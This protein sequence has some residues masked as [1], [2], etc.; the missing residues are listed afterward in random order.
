MC[1]SYSTSESLTILRLPFAAA[2]P[3]SVPPSCVNIRGNISRRYQLIWPARIKKKAHAHTPTNKQRR[4]GWLRGITRNFS[5]A[6]P[7]Q[8]THAQSAHRHPFAASPKRAQ[9][10]PK[11]SPKQAQSKPK[12]SA[13][14]AQSKPKASPKQ[15]QSKPK[16]T[17][18]P[19]DKQRRLAVK[20]RIRQTLLS[21][22]FVK[23][24]YCK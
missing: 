16:A 23:R 14:Q 18:I 3:R 17:R 15:A 8:T 9:S 10:K 1:W 4:L 7:T 13:K 6:Q 19:T 2:C 5:L 24:A 21:G 22:V 11:A 20:C 12:A